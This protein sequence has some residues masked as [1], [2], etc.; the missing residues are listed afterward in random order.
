MH[1]LVDLKAVERWFTVL[2]ILLPLLGIGIGAA[3]QLKAGRPRT[4]SARAVAIGFLV[5]LI[6]PANWLLWHVYNAIEDHY[7][8]DSVKAMLLNL[9]L[10]VAL[11][12]LIGAGVQVFKFSGVRGQTPGRSDLNAPERP[13]A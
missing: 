2:A 13:N 9:A 6:G 8:L 11:G 12:V 7:G 5:G 4:P 1:E 3:V 10:F